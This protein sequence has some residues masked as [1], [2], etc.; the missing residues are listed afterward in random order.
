MGELE[1][2]LDAVLSDPEQMSRIAQMASRLM[3]SIAPEAGQEAPATPAAPG[4]DPSMLAMIGRLGGKIKGN[5]GKEQLIRGLSP[6]LSAARRERLERA[7]RMAAAATLAGAA[8]E[9]MGGE[10]S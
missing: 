5:Q 10:R 4:L 9:E 3:G 7:L 6:Y 2:R 1:E 8:L